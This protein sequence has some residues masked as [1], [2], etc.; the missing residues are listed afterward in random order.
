[1]LFK[2]LQEDQKFGVKNEVSGEFCKPCYTKCKPF[3]W[4]PNQ[5]K[6]C[7]TEYHGKKGYWFLKDDTEVKI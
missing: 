6:N 1:M 4:K 5:P 7:Y 3:N 2:E